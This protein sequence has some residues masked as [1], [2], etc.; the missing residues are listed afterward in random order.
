MPAWRQLAEHVH[1]RFPSAAVVGK[2]DGPAND[3]PVALAPL[4]ADKFPSVFFFP[5]HAA[6]ARAE[7]A[8]AAGGD[9]GGG[10]VVEFDPAGG[11]TLEALR[12]F[13]DLHL[14]D[15]APDATD[16]PDVSATTMTDIR[17]V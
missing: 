8:V 5:S 4:L 6:R 2:M 1:R 3:A 12:A 10:R 16:A 14:R 17:D 7:A 9:G 11:R 13:A 15:L